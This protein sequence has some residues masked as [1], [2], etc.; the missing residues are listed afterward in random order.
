MGSTCLYFIISLFGGNRL[1]TRSDILNYAQETYNTLSEHLWAKYPSYEVLRHKRNRKWFAMIMDVP[2]NKVGL[3]GNELIDILNVKC[4]P[5]IVELL[6]TQEGYSRAYHMNK[7]H[8]LTAI[9][10]ETVSEEDI[11]SLIDTS[12]LLTQ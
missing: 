3:E 5:E 2:K 12:Y 10:D 11:Y 7:E 4:E 1:V 9:L 8:W 6:H